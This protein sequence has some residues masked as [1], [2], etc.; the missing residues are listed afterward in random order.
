MTQVPTICDS[1]PLSGGNYSPLVSARGG[2]LE[3]VSD[4]C[5]AARRAAVQVIADDLQFVSDEG[6]G[7]LARDAP[8]MNPVPWPWLVTR[9]VGP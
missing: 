7:E 3:P 9:L 5:R 8:G 4:C 1:K 2:E 6:V